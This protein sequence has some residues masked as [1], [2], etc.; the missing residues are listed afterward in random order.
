MNSLCEG[1]EDQ[2]Q[3]FFQVVGIDIRVSIY[4]GIDAWR[5]DVDLIHAL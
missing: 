2:M 1:N 4:E 3:G 5:I